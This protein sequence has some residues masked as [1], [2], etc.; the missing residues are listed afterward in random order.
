[1]RHA[2]PQLLALL[3]MA[4][5]KASAQAC[6]VASD[7]MRASVD[8]FLLSRTDSAFRAKHKSSCCGKDQT[9]SSALE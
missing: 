4:T 6:S 1:M 7:A 8:R 9:G 2:T 5:I 3:S